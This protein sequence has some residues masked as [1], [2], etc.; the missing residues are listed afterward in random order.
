MN[1]FLLAYTGDGDDGYAKTFTIPA[2]G[3]SITQ[4]ANVEHD[5]NYTAYNNLAQIDADS[6]VLAMRGTHT[7]TGTSSNGAYVRTLDTPALAT[8]TVPRISSVA[9]AADNSTVAVTWNEPVYSTNGGSGALAASDFSMSISGGTATLSSSTP[10]SISASG[11]TYTLGIGLSGTANGSERL[12][13]GTPA[14]SI[15]DAQGNAASNTQATASAELNKVYLN[16]KSVPVIA[17]TSMG[18]FNENIVVT[19]SES[20]FPA[21]NTS[22]ILATSDFSLSLSGGTATLSSSTPTSISGDNGPTFTLGFSVSGMSNGSEVITVSVLD[23]SIYDAN[24]MEAS[25]TQSNNTA[26]LAATKLAQVA[27]G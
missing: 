17:S 3:S 23:N 14:N 24:G 15:F 18:D 25:T 8:A 7:H 9:L 6:Y 12:V 16:D 4:V 21:N 19:F 22:G 26:T 13:V 11:N 27:A 5:L 20:V 1:T 10:T 2:D